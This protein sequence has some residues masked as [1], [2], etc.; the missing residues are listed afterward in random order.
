MLKDKMA[1]AKEAYKAAKENYIKN[2]TTENW[3]KFCDAKKECMLL[4]VRI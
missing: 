4:G 3:I 2:R 1:A